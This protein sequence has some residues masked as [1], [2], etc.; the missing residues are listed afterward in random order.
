MCCLPSDFLS[1][2]RAPGRIA[3][4]QLL[5]GVLWLL[6]AVCAP[7]MLGAGGDLALAQVD[8]KLCALCHTEV[9]ADES[10]RR[11]H[12]DLSC[13]ECHADLAAWDP[14][15]ESDHPEH[16]AKV[17]CAPCHADQA[18]AMSR[19]VHRASSP[20]DSRPY[21]R[22]TSCHGIPHFQPLYEERPAGARKQ[23][24]AENCSQCHERKS[25]EFAG[26]AHHAALEKGDA[27]APSCAECHGAH[28]VLS[29]LEAR[30]H[31]NVSGA[32][33]RCAACHAD[34]RA[35]MHPALEGG[36]SP[37][38]CLACHAGHRTDAKSIAER[39]FSE[40]GA[41]KCALCHA[42]QH[43][44]SLPADANCSSCHE[45]HREGASTIPA[46]AAEGCVKCHAEQLTALSGSAHDGMQAS[47]SQCHATAPEGA[48]SACPEEIVRTVDCARC[49]R[50][51]D[52]SWR[53]S[54][55][56]STNGSEH[57]AA[58]CVDCHGGHEA[59][60]SEDP[61]SKTYPI[62]LPN[63]CESCHQVGARPEHPA[64]AGEK[65]QRYET[66]VHGRGL[67]VDGLVVTATCASCHG[68]HDIRRASDAQAP[69][70]RKNVP[71][72]CGSCH[73]GILNNYLEGVHGAA[74]KSGS[75]D[76]PVCNDCHVEHAVEDPAMAGSSVSDKLVAETCA[77]CHGDDEFAE[78][79]SLKAGVRAS[80]GT[81]YH[82][83]ASSL[84]A[85]GA[86]NCA[87]C[88]GFHDI[89]P[90]TDRRSSIHVDK[91]DQT[92]GACHP[93][94]SAAFARVPVH[95]TLD[96]ASNPIPYW[97]KTIYTVLVVVVIGAFVLFILFDLW[98]RLRLRMGWG[99][100]ETH[101]ITHHE[102]P[103][104]DR[105]VAPDEKFMRMG[106]HG[107]LQHAILVSSFLLLV[108]TGVPVFLHDVGFMRSLIDLEGGYALRSQLHRVGAI[109]LV[110]LSLWH[111]VVIALSGAARRWVMSMMFR[112]RDILDFAQ[113][114]LFDLG[115]GA[116][117]VKLPFLRPILSRFPAL[118]GTERPCM[119]RYGLV[120]K[121]EYGAV[122]WGNL[123]MILTG[124][125]LWR[126]DW[127]LDWMPSWTFDV[128]RVVHGFEAT[129][130]FLAIII[131]HMYHVHLRPGVFP[132]S[133]VWLDGKI[134]RKELRHHHPG[135][136]LAILRERRS[137][138]GA[139]R[140][141]RA[142]H[143]AS[144]TDHA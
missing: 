106:R 20:A 11:S 142:E 55:H 107:R 9:K 129:L 130:A 79:H 8:D 18:K 34:A 83:I 41:N 122:V 109:G 22:C 1:V 36:A 65:V 74:F 126:P 93:N 81:S 143:P 90:S 44:G 40:G 30:S 76:V 132:M 73:A 6:L 75:E 97:V 110:G 85:E 72:T 123:V 7:G 104:E 57:I 60:G 33:Q 103:D 119:G 53:K 77:R 141:A 45:F 47:C 24:V 114:M 48:A 100:P 69:T 95:S 134:T 137:T 80:W 89:F 26:S 63:T 94:A 15:S 92:C 32:S 16:L 62:N 29:P 39:T 13:T 136:Y 23:A 66:S 19:S 99:P 140:G 68:G 50:D 111:L 78:R 5:R 71:H 28:D 112:P 102:W 2:I 59:R 58:S 56:V 116:W 25:E 84:G 128:C 96:E 98:G 101:H 4:M 61:L 133:R 37:L 82:G 3:A 138:A 49:H 35:S 113:E 64:P 86:A 51:A 118:A 117:L 105:L 21:P 144:D 42:G 43:A 27:A 46:P 91:L 131:W 125:I 115:I 120:E 124:A 54:P 108:V 127:F 70:A 121:L 67:R 17:N 88:H 14:A 139:A 87:S 31:M 12:V 10:V 135:E 52:V 38:S